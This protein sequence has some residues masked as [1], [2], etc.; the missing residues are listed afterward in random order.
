MSILQHIGDLILSTTIR[1]LDHS[2][3]L[4][5]VGGNVVVCRPLPHFAHFI[6]ITPMPH[7]PHTY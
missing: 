6:P 1:S 7:W 5:I 2:D 4:P 3:S